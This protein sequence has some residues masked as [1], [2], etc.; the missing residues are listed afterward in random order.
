MTWSIFNHWPDDFSV[1]RMEVKCL[2]R[3]HGNTWHGISSVTPKRLTFSIKLLTSGQGHVF[4]KG[5]G[6]QCF[7]VSTFWWCVFKKERY[8][9]RGICPPWRKCFQLTRD[10]IRKIR[11]KCAVLRWSTPGTR[12]THI[13]A[14]TYMQSTRK[15]YQKI[16]EASPI[17]MEVSPVLH[18]FPL[19][20]KNGVCI[21]RRVAHGDALDGCT[22]SW[23]T[24]C[25]V[26]EIIAIAI[27]IIVCEKS[28]AL[29]S[30]PGLWGTREENVKV[31]TYNGL[32]RGACVHV[33]VTLRHGMCAHKREILAIKASKWMKLPKT[34]RERTMHVRSCCAWCS[35]KRIFTACVP[36]VNAN[37]HN[38]PWISRTCQE[39]MHDFAWFLLHLHEK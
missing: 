1:Q 31:S 4:R 12:H 19:V 7:Q 32:Q 36:A 15:L 37:K 33:N 6:F 14:C 10:K 8:F 23:P 24:A 35:G 5:W 26:P 38:N 29:A 9:E 30:W 28:L 34:W 13:Y 20:I 2:A 27:F 17:E 25:F 21:C 39:T 18:E 3:H 16:H 11:G 22:F